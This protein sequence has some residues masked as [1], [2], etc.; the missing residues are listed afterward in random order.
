MNNGSVTPFVGVLIEIY[1]A[2]LLTAGNIVTPFVGVLI[3]I[4]NVPDA[5]TVI[6]SLPS[7]EC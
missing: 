5:H 3:E 2:T 4:Q 6:Q 7:W 1:P